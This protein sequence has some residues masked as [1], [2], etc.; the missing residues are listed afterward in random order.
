YN[1]FNISD[2]IYCHSLQTSFSFDDAVNNC[3]KI[4]AALAFFDDNAEYLTA[5]QKIIVNASQEKQTWI[6]FNATAVNFKYVFYW[7]KQKFNDS[8]WASGQPND[9][10]SYRCACG[11]GYIPDTDN[12][13]CLD[14]DECQN[15]T[16][17]HSCINTIGS[18]VCK[19]DEGFILDSLD[20]SSCNDVDECQEAFQI[21]NQTCDV[22]QDSNISACQVN[23]QDC[24][25]CDQF[26]LNTN[27]SYLCTCQTGYGLNSTDNTTC[28]D[29]DEC[30]LNSSLCE[31]YCNNT[32]GSY[33]CSCPQGYHL[34]ENKH[35]CNKKGVYSQCPCRCFGRKEITNVTSQQLK[36]QLETL[37]KDIQVQ[38][39]NLLSTKLLLTCQPDDRPASNVIGYVGIVML[40]FVFGSVAYV[41]LASFFFIGSWLNTNYYVSSLDYKKFNISGRIYC[42]SLQTSFTFDDAVNNCLKIGAALAFFDDNA[43][44]LTAFQKIIVNASQEKQTWITFNA[45][46]VN[47]KYVFY[48]KKQK[49]NDS[50]WASG[51]PSDQSNTS[52]VDVN[53]CEQNTS[54]CEG[55]C[56]NTVGSYRCTCN[57][58][59]KLSGSYLCVDIDECSLGNHTCQQVC[60]N[61]IGSYHCNCSVGY[62]ASDSGQCLD[63]NECSIG[64]KPCQ[65]TC[66]NTNG[67]FLCSCE[68]GWTLSLNRRNCTLN[69][70]C[71]S[72]PCQ[73]E[74]V[75]TNTSFVC[76]CYPG[77]TLHSNGINCT[78]IDECKSSVCQHN[79]TN[80]DGSYICTCLYGY[81]LQPDNT[82]CSDIDECSNNI[83]L[84]SDICRNTPGGY[85]CGCLDGFRVVNQNCS[86][87]DEC[88]NTLKN[89]CSH[90][91]NNTEGSYTCWCDDGYRLSENLT[92]CLDIDEC[93][94]YT[95]RCSD[96][97]INTIGSY[98]CA[99]GPGY[100]PDAD[101]IT[102]LDVDECHNITCGH[103][104]VN[105]IG[106]YVCQCDEGF[107]LDT[108]NISA[109]NDVDEC[110]EASQS[111]NQTCD[112]A[113]DS[114]ISACQ[115]IDRESNRPHYHTAELENWRSTL[116][117]VRN[118]RGAD[119]GS[120]HHLVVA[121]L[122][123]KL[124]SSKTR[125]NKRKRFDLDKLHNTQ[126]KKEFQQSLQN[127]FAVLQLNE[128]EQSVDKCLQ[129]FKEFITETSNEVLSLNP[130][131]KKQW[132]SDET[133][134]LIKER[135]FA[136]QAV[137]LLKTRNH[138]QQ[139]K[140]DY[141]AVSQKT[142]KLLRQDKRSFYNNLAEQA[143]EAADSETNKLNQLVIGNVGY[144][145]SDFEE[146]FVDAE[147]HCNETGTTLAFFDDNKEFVDVY[148]YTSKNISTD[149]EIWIKINY[150]RN[151]SN[152]MFFW[153]N[154]IVDRKLWGKDEPDS[155]CENFNDIT[156]C[157]KVTFLRNAVS[158]WNGLRDSPCSNMYRFLCKVSL[159]FPDHVI[160]CLPD[161]TSSK[162]I[163]CICAAG[164]WFNE[165]SLKCQPLNCLTGDT[166][167][168]S[169]RVVPVSGLFCDCESGYTFG[170]NGTCVDVNECLVNNACEQNCTNSFGSF[171]CSCHQGYTLRADNKT[172]VA[173]SADCN[174]SSQ[175]F[176]HSC[177]N[178]SCPCPTSSDERNISDFCS[179]SPCQHLCFNTSTHFICKCYAGHVL[180]ADSVHCSPIEHCN[181]SVCLKDCFTA[182]DS[183]ACTDQCPESDKPCD[184]ACHNTNDSYI[185]SCHPGYFLNVADNKTCHDIDECS[186]NSSLCEVYCNN[187]PG[188]YFC[189]CPQGYQL[190]GN[191][192]SCNQN[193]PQSQ[194]PCQCSSS[195]KRKMS[196]EA[197]KETLK[198]LQQELQIDTSS[199][200][201]TQL[202][203]TSQPDDRPSSTAIG[204]FGI[205]FL[206][207]VLGLICMS[208]V[209]TLL[210]H[211]V[212]KVKINLNGGKK[213]GTI[214]RA[215]DDC[216]QVKGEVALFETNKEFK[217]AADIIVA[218][219][220]I[221]S[222]GVWIRL[223]LTDNDHD[224]VYEQNWKNETVEASAWASGE[225]SNCGKMVNSSMRCNPFLNKASKTLAYANYD[226][227]YN[228]LCSTVNECVDGSANCSQVCVDSLVGYNCSCYSGYALAADKKSCSDV[229]ECQGKPC[230]QVCNN[231][232]GSFACSC[233]DGY[234]FS[235][236]N[237]TCTD[238]DE[239][240]SG[241]CEHECSNRNGSFV[242]SCHSGYQLSHNN[243]S[244]DDVNE[245]TNMTVHQCQHNCINFLGS[246]YCDCRIGYSLSLD[247]HNCTDL[248]ECSSSPCHQVCLNN[249]GSY[250]CSC[251][252]G[253]TMDIDHEYCLD[254]DECYNASLNQCDHYCTNTNGS[255]T[256]SCKSGFSL[257]SNGS[258]TDIDEC[259]NTI[260]SQVCSNQY[261]SYQCSCFSGYN[262]HSDHINCVDINECDPPLNTCDHVC[263]NS[264]GSFNC[265]CYKGYLLVSG[266]GTCV[267]VDE[268]EANETLCEGPCTNT[269]GGYTCGCQAGYKLESS[270]VCE[271]I[272]EC[273]DKM[274]SCSQLCNNTQGSYQCTFCLNN[275][276][277]YTCSCSA[278]YTMD[279]DHEYCLDIDECYNASLNQCDHYCTNTNGSFTCSCKTGFSL[280]SNGSC[281]D[282]D[283]CINTTC[284]QVC[285]NQYGSYQCT[286]FSGY[287]LHSDNINCVDI[288]ECDPPLNMCDHVCL[289]SG[290]S[291]N[292]SCNKGYLLVS[293]N[294][295]C[296]DVDE[297][298][299]NETLCEGPCTNTKGGYT[300]GCQAGYKLGSSG[301]CE[302]I[303]EC[304]DK[305]SSCSQLCNNTQGSYQCTCEYGYRP[306]AGQPYLC[307][308][309][310]ECLEGRHTCNQT[311]INVNGSY[312]C[313]CKSG[314]LLDPLDLETCLDVDECSS[315]DHLCHHVCTNTPGSFHCSCHQGFVMNANSCVLKRFSN[316]CPCSCQHLDQ[317]KQ[318][319]LQNTLQELV[320]LKQYLAIIKSDLVSYKMLKSCQNDS[321]FTSTAMGYCGLAV[322][323]V[324]FGVLV[325]PDILF[326]LTWLIYRIQRRQKIRR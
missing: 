180:L 176:Q 310:D 243:V 266:N 85:L 190:S 25:L 110:L 43:E 50:V 5:F 46:A 84:C 174:N 194:C 83:S 277:S 284:S 17:G 206:A 47:F 280:S 149:S 56:Q 116:L 105:T 230:H 76:R 8:V 30:S 59:Y 302:D 181:R 121:K 309:I 26:C 321:R 317:Q 128:A 22:A 65:Q 213:V 214:D 28:Y 62:I 127:R 140:Q 223:V 1:I 64:A 215:E 202:L 86:D 209:L 227:Q 167:C 173:I 41:I 100:I 203:Y 221:N 20:M 225:P 218:K 197:I 252:A 319:N 35:S 240:A 188:S 239:C 278:G 27:G 235:N 11:P 87:I 275:E 187:T 14:V 129:N 234:A 7:K 305:M 244:C 265:S 78:D 210:G 92:T 157:S 183:R 246:Y 258:C 175:T 69:D 124:A 114:N 18:F 55:A 143:E 166:K 231:T 161:C 250:T 146:T 90:H 155:S 125:I 261:G 222:M 164:Y 97:C 298:E 219:Y 274:S 58:G 40:T 322:V 152:S 291:F 60:V 271:D 294:G 147:R 179:S 101:N 267:D 126:I 89:N 54:L 185:C 296:V 233:F 117:D 249:E 93:E 228:Y 195:L 103:R 184:H 208:D 207:I 67:S 160:N 162:T 177:S 172:C 142:T 34:S 270:G 133:W 260:C 299:T 6:T 165:S 288:N 256:C 300:C 163:R 107:I 37:S 315:T 201:S 295:T 198:V 72:S 120:Y 304:L 3:L 13:T 137:N 196:S 273:L 19:C 205:V 232:P 229:D 320:K 264:D 293:G 108:L 314:F 31:F 193:R 307:V 136:K 262:L 311:C 53:E 323:S 303:D 286:C 170:Q 192:Q 81:N 96:I 191:R 247:K 178:E 68:T 52:C 263:L 49:F 154:E 316:Y 292:C 36:E 268:C 9:E 118:R 98:R 236:D 61:V 204:Y 106:S 119:I 168:L 16:C 148:N 132:I 211:M 226:Y 253:Y 74:C 217:T 238:I 71:V 283:E 281:T 44:Y 21:C 70:E 4:G 80:T 95:Y 189:S 287:N 88:E 254:I 123:R 73:H 212:D 104:C 242:C 169:C 257:S 75:H 57:T 48:W 269:K 153:R 276:G 91:C 94:E 199:L 33:F 63:I 29:I 318:F 131:K 115:T 308:D 216:K 38:E 251:S 99:C 313:A 130:K 45:T 77:Y 112:V 186:L 134:K 109:C 10:C 32:P 325:I 297:C 145:L 158:T 2:R 326:M 151:E 24:K 39:V 182:N 248:D 312:Q 285:S 79:C 282:I 122:K 156:C 224:M 42:H 255:F 279:I 220:S 150:T 51:E 290:G 141:Q 200:L 272:D 139:S 113:P 111:C 102:C 144:C 15:I 138:K 289:N 171:H 241:P 301:V 237:Y 306:Q 12:I 23:V 324:V 66:T 245:C 135:K 159:K 82:S 259:I